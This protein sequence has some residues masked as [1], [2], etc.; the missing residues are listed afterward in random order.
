[1]W[2]LLRWIRGRRIRRACGIIFLLAE[3][4]ETLAVSLLHRSIND[5][6]MAGAA[7]AGTDARCV[8]RMP[9]VLDARILTVQNVTIDSA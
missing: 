6:Y 8:R 2:R 5:Y 1:M 9:K 7:N 4:V 3:D